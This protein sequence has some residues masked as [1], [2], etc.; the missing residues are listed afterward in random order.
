LKVP[1]RPILT[2]L[3]RHFRGK[4]VKGFGKVP[5]PHD[6]LGAAVGR[7]NGVG[8]RAAYDF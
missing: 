1:S 3:E 5:W 6:P 8:V 7:V 4:T 2:Q